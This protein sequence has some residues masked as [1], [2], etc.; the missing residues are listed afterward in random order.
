VSFTT[1]P[2]AT[3]SVTVS[4]PN[5]VGAFSIAASACNGIVSAAVSGSGSQSTITLTPQAVGTCTIT[6][7]GGAGQSATFEI[8]V[9][10]TSITSN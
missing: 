4:Q 6:V 1:L 3:Q 8:A 2:A 5:H 9:T 7:G 10:T